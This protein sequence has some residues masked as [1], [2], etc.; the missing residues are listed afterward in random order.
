MSKILLVRHAQSANNSLPEEA[1]VCDPGLTPL[2]YR[3]AEALAEQLSSYSIRSLYCSPFLRSLET[4][5][6]V[7]QATG[8][9]PT[10][11]NDLFEQGGCY[12]GYHSGQEKGEPGMGRL[13]LA[14]R[15]PGWKID[16]RI[17]ASGWWGRPYETRAQAGQRASAVRN[18]LEQHV[19]TD[20]SGLDVLVI[21]ADF[22]RLM[23]LE[24]LGNAWSDQHDLQLGP[25]ANAGVTVMEYKRSL[26]TLHAYN[27]V[28]HLRPHEQSH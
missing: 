17:A 24:M 3:Q 2:G 10:I 19:V 21:H 26:W 27:S 11:H 23:L 20:D 16:E 12:S 5:R 28:G 1:R 13:E 25:L 4:A 8:L 15:Y 9:P 22:K 14:E 7:A 6:M 18:W